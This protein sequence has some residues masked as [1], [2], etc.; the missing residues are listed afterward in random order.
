MAGNSNYNVP[1]MSTLQCRHAGLLLSVDGAEMGRILH[2]T[3]RSLKLT[4]AKNGLKLA[5]YVRL[6]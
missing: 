3:C 2:A 6:G 4:V 5:S 1:S